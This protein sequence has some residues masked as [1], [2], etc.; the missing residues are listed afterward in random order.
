M[1]TV[2][3]RPGFDDL[4]PVGDGTK[5]IISAFNRAQTIVSIVPRRRV[6]AALL[7]VSVVL[8]YSSTPVAADSPA[9]VPAGFADELVYDGLV[10]PMAVAFAPNGNVFVAEKSGR[11]YVYSDLTDTTPTLFADLNTNVHNYWDRGLM[12]LAVDP[13]FPTD[14]YVYVLYAYNHI[15]GSAAAPPR[16]P[17]ADT[18]VPPGSP[19]DDRC[20][21]PPQ[22]TGDGCVISGR[23]SRLAS[24][25]G[26]WDGNEHV[27][28]EDWC[29][30]FPSHSVGSLMFGPEGALYVSGGDGASFNSGTPDYGQL[31]GTL[32]GTPTPVNPCGDPGGSAPAPPSAEGGALR[33]QDIRTSGDP[34]GLD[35]AILRVDPDTGAGWSTNA[36]HA[37]G[38]ANA[39]RI[40]AYGLRN[41]YRFTIRPGT[42]DVWIGD[43]GFSTWEELD[44]LPNPAAAPLNFG[45]PCWEGG[46]TLPFFNDIGLALCDSLNA[47]SVTLPT[48]AYN[49]GSTVVSGDGCGTGS[50]SISGLAFLSSTSG[51]PNGYDGALFMT[52]YS[53]NCIWVFPAGA[54]GEPNIGAR[55]RFADLRRSDGSADGGAVFLSTV[56][57][58]AAKYAGDLIYADY[59]RGE[60]RVV[61]YYG[62]NVPP[63]ASFTATPSSGQA[64]LNVTF[65]ASASTDANNDP[66]TYAWDLDGDGQYDDATGVT[67]SRTYTNSGDVVVGLRVQDPLAAFGTATQTVSV[68]NSPPSVTIDAPS[69]SLTWAVGDVIDFSGTGTDLQDGT[70]PAS[71]FAWELD[72]E[73]CPSDC[74]THII[75]TFTGVKS[76]SFEAPDHEYP[77]HLKL[78]V[79]VTDTGGL[80]DTAMVELYPKTGT[81]AGDTTPSGIQITV[82]E[83]TGSPPPPA[84][85]IVGSTVSVSAP[86]DVDIGEDIW[87]FDHWSDAGPRTHAVPV[88]SGATTVTATFVKTGTTDAADA[89]QAAAAPSKPSGAWSFGTFSS[90]DDVDWYRFKLSKTKRVRMVLGDLSGSGRLALYQGCSKLL[91]V[92]DRAGSGA[93]QIIRNLAAGTY[94]IRLSGSESTSDHAVLIKKI[95]KGVHVLTS[96]AQTAGGSLRLVGEVY[97]NTSGT[98]GPVDVTA[99]LYD[100]SDNLLATRTA[101]VKLKFVKSHSRAP[102]S[103]A[104][105]ALVGFDHV[106]WDVTA[107]ATGKKVVKPRS[108]VTTSGPDSDDHWA[109]TGTV[110]NNKAAKI[111]HLRFAIALY[112]ARGNVVGVVRAKVGTRTLSPGASTTFAATFLS[113][114]VTPDRIYRRGMAIR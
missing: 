3:S 48:F 23:L 56:P 42:D 17:S 105:P 44:K 86:A 97:N 54:G 98:V 22:A 103:I 84:T 35:G 68:G 65:D 73:H 67:T 50:S 106:S 95:R 107:P 20:P 46:A 111:K 76:G 34:V 51:Y 10:H 57:S 18:L 12:G 62:A 9:T 21:N 38:D 11:I 99:R 81:V 113:T 53:R 59:D 1:S 78:K 93:E 4:G 69:S 30:Q 13:G 6:F 89:C 25:G 39:R 41:P 33:S 55:F 96:S 19:Y 49:H 36:N 102:F 27:L 60:I 15:L 8:P 71:A 40:I 92:S 26:V 82:G 45:W 70:L 87:S 90:D 61:H 14:P 31:G 94:A 47:G 85:G 72:M 5:V 63:V 28:I 108:S 24:S 2:S 29:Q 112:D 83:K 43:V 114:G 100:S 37:E 80:T 7:L 75:Q 109:M 58:D 64:P 101:T 16:W 77:S 110:T 91:A 66:L 88:V 79:T 52:D 32:P 74:H 104:G